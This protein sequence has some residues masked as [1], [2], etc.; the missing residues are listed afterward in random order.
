MRKDV[1]KTVQGQHIVESLYRDILANPSWP[2]FDQLS[3]PT[4]VARTHVL[5]FGKISNP[6]LLMLHGSA[7]N[8]AVWLGNVRDFMNHFCV[9]CVDIPGEPGLSEPIR[10]SLHSDEPLR[11]LISLLDALDIPAC[12]FLT[13]SLGSWYSLN[14]AINQPERVKAISMLT[15][16]GI[17]PA[18]AS[19]LFMA[20]F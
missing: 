18:K 13:M 10:C 14:I 5:R 3:V 11:W 4:A 16:P 2:A 12:S 7:S 17:V 6:P 19:F 20:I 8:S 15:T 9:Y 1:Y